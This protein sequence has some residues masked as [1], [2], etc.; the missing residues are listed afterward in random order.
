MSLDLFQAICLPVMLVAY[1]Y[2]IM[3]AQDRAR[4]VVEIIALAASGWIGEHTV[5]EAYQFYFYADGWWPKLG[6]VPLL[7]ALIWPMVVLSARDVARYLFGDQSTL[8][9][10][11]T[12]GG[13]VVFD[14]SIMEVIAV[15]AGFWEW[16]EPG[17]LNVPLMG[18][19]GW[20]CF[21][22]AATLWLDTLEKRG[23]VA[24]LGSS[25]LVLVPATH[26][27]LLAVWWGGLRWGLRGD[28]GT[29]GFVGFAVLAALYAGKIVE[30]QLKRDDDGTERADGIGSGKLP[31]MVTAPRVLATSVFIALLMSLGEGGPQWGHLAIAA[32]PYAMAT[33]W[34]ERA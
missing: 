24:L 34:P 4:R 2:S 23:S 21:G 14:A 32:V 20:G 9:R 22:F 1:A 16:F 33:R 17:Y 31:L 3:S 19:V 6:H 13:I 28:L 12:V 25:P 27:L 8:K 15:Q 29:F 18:I 5:I 30:A 7:V 10:A 11:L 26:L